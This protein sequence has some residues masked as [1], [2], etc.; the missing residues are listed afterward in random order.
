MADSSGKDYDDFAK[1]LRSIYKSI[2]MT[3]RRHLNEKTEGPEAPGK[4]ASGGPERRW[5]NC[6]Y[7]LFL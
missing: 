6:F 2:P 4:V 7:P 3:W 5:N 1:A